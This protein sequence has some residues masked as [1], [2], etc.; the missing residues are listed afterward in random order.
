MSNPGINHYVLTY[1]KDKLSLSLNSNITD[2][3]KV[4]TVIM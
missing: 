4:V 1:L 2:I 3:W